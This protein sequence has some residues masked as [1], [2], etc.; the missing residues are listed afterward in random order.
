MNDN[1]LGITNQLELRNKEEKLSKIRAKELF[2]LDVINDFEVGTYQG[3]KDIH[4]YLFQDIYPFAGKERTGNI[5]KDYFRF[6]PAIY[7]NASLKQIDKMPMST[8]DEIVEKY[9]EMNIAHPFKEGNGRSTRIWLDIIL[10]KNLKRVIDWN[11]IDKE[12]YLLAMERSP[13]KD[14]EIKFFLNKALTNK[15]DDRKTYMT[16]IDISF[17]YENFSSYLINEISK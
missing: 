12:D 13:I 2:D 10:R 3:L 16:G 4:N 1:L 9:V 6:T 5:S 17:Y 7:L 8:F 15:I 11:L 14:I